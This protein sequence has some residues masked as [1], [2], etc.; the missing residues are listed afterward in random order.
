MNK[1]LLVFDMDG[2]LVDVTASY[3]EAIAATVEHFTGA[4]PSNAQIQEAK[5]AGNANDDWRLTHRMIAQAGTTVE[6]E[7]VKA[8]FQQLFLGENND[9]LILRERWVP[10]PG[11]LEELNS[12]FRFAVFTGRPRQE[13][14]FT[15][16]RFAPGLVFHP[17]IAMEDVAEHKPAPEGLLAI[18]QA[19]RGCD[20]FY[21]GDAVD[22]ARSARAARV[23][24]IGIAA[25]SNP[26]Y[27]DLVFLFQA[28]G[29]YAIVDDVNY[30][31]EVFAE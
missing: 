24:F 20:L 28:E 30:L 15:L 21:V 3:R 7:P 27:L 13:A 4:R 16:R 5:N 12:R 14:E 18:A 31:R 1:P 29:A 25:P 9:G 17:L 19:N 26:L 10:Q 23:P 6:F 2:V 8:R 22:D 11:A